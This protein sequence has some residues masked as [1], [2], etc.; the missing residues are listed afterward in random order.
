[1]IYDVLKILKKIVMFWYVYVLTVVLGFSLYLFLP[2]NQTIINYTY[3][4]EFRIEIFNNNNVEYYNFAQKQVLKNLILDESKIKENLEA[5]INKDFK[6]AQT[7]VNILRLTVTSK[8]KDACKTDY[9]AI[10]DEICIYIKNNLLEGYSN[11]K[12]EISTYQIGSESESANAIKR[13]FSKLFKAF[14]LVAFAEVVG[15]GIWGTIDDKIISSKELKFKFNKN[16]IV[17]NKQNDEEFYKFKI[18][19]FEK[20]NKKVSVLKNV[21]DSDALSSFKAKEEVLTADVVLIEVSLDKTSERKLAKIVEFLD[22][23][24]KKEVYF[25][26]DK[27]YKEVKVENTS[28]K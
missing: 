25:V 28:N 4:S 23:N 11:T 2:R 12:A 21:N 9:Q 17:E 7:D 10:K 20:E 1:M 14:I 8:S 3:S 5:E 13:D 27:N 19:Q 22:N 26:V 6:L 18:K 16:V 15:F 24:N